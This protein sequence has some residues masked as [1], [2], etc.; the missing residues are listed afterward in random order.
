MSTKYSLF[1]DK[2][3]HIYQ[4]CFDE[5]YVY[6][7]IEENSIST[8]IKLGL[9]EIISLLRGFDLEKVK[10]QAEITD[11][12]IKNYCVKS[13]KARIEDKN[14]MSKL[15]GSIVFGDPEWPEEKQVQAGIE[16]YTNKRNDLK[17]IID[18]VESTPL[19]WGFYNALND[20][21]S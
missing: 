11:D 19:R 3:T 6:I 16:F 12:E 21:K 2:K 10:K 15:F 20:I 9:K 14:P 18:E 8:K 4:E 7:D 17:K 13:V 5:N 1:F